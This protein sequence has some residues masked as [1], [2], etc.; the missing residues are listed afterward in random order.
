MR[1]ITFLIALMLISISFGSAI[2]TTDEKVIVSVKTHDGRETT[3]ILEAESASRLEM[4]FQETMDNLS[5]LP[6]ILQELQ[7]YG[8]LDNA[9]E[10]MDEIYSLVKNERLHEK[11]NLM[12]NAFCL[13]AGY[14]TNSW[15][16]TPASLLTILFYTLF[17]RLEVSPI[18]LKLLLYSIYFYAI[19]T[20]KI[21]LPAAA[22]I[23]AGYGKVCSIGLLGYQSISTEDGSPSV[24]I[25]FR[26]I[27]VAITFLWKGYEETYVAGAAAAIFCV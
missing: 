8:L 3:K 5:I 25:L 1:G 13:L 20:P 15:I 10:M 14:G 4:M 26:F 12:L 17:E 24:C 27:G 21:Y 16:E 6:F 23:M 19:F 11:M 18:L 2:Q 9:E 22:W 7:N